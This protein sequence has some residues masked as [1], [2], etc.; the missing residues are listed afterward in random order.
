MSLCNGLCDRLAVRMHSGR[1]EPPYYRRLKP[2]LLGALEGEVVEI[3]PGSGINLKYYQGNVRWTGVEPNTFLH[4]RI[5]QRAS[6]LGFAPRL[7]AGSAERLDFPDGRIDV[8]VGT[9]VLCSVGD[10]A[11][12]LA[13]VLRVLRPGGR[14]VFLEHIAA[15]LG[16]RTRRIQE[17]WTPILRRLPG[18]CSPNRDTRQVIERAGFGAVADERFEL[19]TAFGITLPHIAGTATK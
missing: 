17:T 7:L 18:G 14:Y 9:L 4:E 8:V 2:E 6:G 19:P 16:S 10:P 5:R 3:G 12:A 15:P 13:E 1:W 11:R